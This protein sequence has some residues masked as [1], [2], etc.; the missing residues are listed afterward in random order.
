MSTEHGFELTDFGKSRTEALTDGIF[1]IAMTILVLNLDI[2]SLPKQP[3]DVQVWQAIVKVMP[4]AL[5]FVASFITLGMY[6]VSHHSAFRFLTRSDRTVLWLNMYFLLFASLVP[7][8]TNL[9]AGDADSR[10]ANAVF[11]ANLVI[12]G[13]LTY[14]MW[15]YACMRKFIAEDMPG[16][17]R[18][19]ITRRILTA[20]LLAA[21]ALLLSQFEPVWAEAVYFGM[22]P[23][24]MFSVRRIDL[25]S[26]PHSKHS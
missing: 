20:P 10:V 2:P 26:V 15:A 13:L 1:A 8:T 16:E 17:V 22:V 7:F 18:R 11:G 14:A 23:F 4:N 25:P 6:W 24:F 12:M 19:F 3:T 9:Y 21:L 5:A